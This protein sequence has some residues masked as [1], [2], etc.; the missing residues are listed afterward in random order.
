MRQA[1]FVSLS[2][3]YRVKNDP[4]KDVN[5][6]TGISPRRQ[7]DK[8]ALLCTVRGLSEVEKFQYNIFTQT[9]TVIMST[10]A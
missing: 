4:F 1:S 2:S 9:K 5:Y 8:N 10:G 3:K 6:V 7:H